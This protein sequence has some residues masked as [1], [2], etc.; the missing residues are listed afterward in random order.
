LDVA[1]VESSGVGILFHQARPLQAIRRVIRSVEPELLI[2][3]TKERSILERVLSGSVANDVLRRF[4]CDIL[5]AAPAPE[6]KTC[7][8]ERDTSVND[9]DAHAREA[10]SSR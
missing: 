10:Y 1:G 9:I 8:I 7:S 3:G 2:V 5:V 4:R 6:F